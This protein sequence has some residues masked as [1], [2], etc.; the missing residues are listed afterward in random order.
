[1]YLR[2]ALQAPEEGDAAQGAGGGGSPEG[3]QGKKPEDGDFV[4]ASRLK[5]ALADQE[6]RLR[7][8]QRAESAAL[9]EELAALKKPANLDQ[10]P[11]R[12]TRQELNAAVGAGTIT[13]EQADAQMDLQLRE[14]A[15]AEARRVASAT[16]SAAQREER[17]DRDIARYTAVAPEVLDDS[18]DTRTRIKTEFRALVELGDDPK[19][20]A[21]QLKAIRAVLGPIESLE[22]ARS[23]RTGHDPHQEA[24]GGAG[25]AGR[26]AK[27]FADT[28]DSRTRDH[29]EH[30]IRQGVYANWAAVEEERKFA[31]APR[32]ARA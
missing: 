30:L 8:E 18:H 31:K 9:R 14:D 4:P 27:K 13:Q 28:L 6:R 2:R 3:G 10:Q 7:E 29:Y 19:A 15:G 23:G 1:M 24:G 25:G 12:Y 17:I 16:V 26:P 32:R 5:A 22:R 20:L 11:K 21:T